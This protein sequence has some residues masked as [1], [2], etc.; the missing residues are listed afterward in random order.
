MAKPLVWAHRGACGYAPENTL[1]SFKKA[2]ELGADGIELDVQLTKDDVMVICHDETVDRTSDGTGWIKD[3]TFAELRKLNFNKTFPEQ[4][5]ATIP[6]LEEV[7]AL[8]KPTNLTIN[9]ELKTG[10]VFY[11]DLERKVI[12]L[13]EKM[14]M[15]DRV[16]YSSFNH[17]SCVKIHELRPETYVGFLYADGPIDMAPYAKKHGANALH[18]ALYNL[19]FPNYMQDAAAN[20]LDV[21]V[22][23]VNEPEH[24]GLCAKMGVHAIITNYPDRVKEIIK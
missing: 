2:I 4:G 23:T 13:T 6:T 15:A 18:P 5:R 8:I 10:I 14:G 24:I 17:Y 21:N 19:Q 1:L 11:K 12:E 22:W 20:G 16:I 3:L 7:Y 9:V